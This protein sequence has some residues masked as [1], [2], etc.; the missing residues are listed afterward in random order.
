[1]ND[2]AMV[3]GLEKA[4]IPRDDAVDYAA[5]GC[6]E[7]FVAGKTDFKYGF[8][9]AAE[10]LSRVLSP[11]CWERVEA[12]DLYLAEYDPFAGVEIADPRTYTS[13]DE[14]MAAFKALLKANVAGFVRSAAGMRD[15]RLGDIAP[16]PLL[17]AFVEGPLE[18]GRD[19]TQNSMR[20]HQ[21]SPLLN[22]LAQAA[23]SL[24]AIK[25]LVFDDGLTDLPQLLDA[26]DADWDGYEALR[27]LALTRVPAYGNDIDYVDDIAREVVEYFAECAVELG[28]ELGNGL[29]FTPGLATFEHYPGLGRLVPALPNGRHSGE[30][31]ANNASPT[32]GRA[33]NGETAAINSFLKLPLD[34]LGGGACLDV[35]MQ[36]GAQRLTYL[37]SILAATRGGNVL[38]VTVNDCSKLRAARKDPEK[39][40]DLLVRVAGH[41]AYFVDLPA[42]HQERLIDRCEQYASHG[43]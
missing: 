4:G 36:P 14:V 20:Y 17:S 21:H 29:L 37:E 28:R 33:R 18:T 12:P 8:I 24:A 39:H 43:C 19:L 38:T 42:Y 34:S 13:F 11:A 35:E 27:Q 41:T 32:V 10:V 30:P 31:L 26:I 16:D 22:G 1:M 2:E 40:R 6:F 15:G 23:D 9:N 7:V 25:K 5:S 3:C